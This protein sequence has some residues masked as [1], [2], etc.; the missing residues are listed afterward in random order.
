MGKPREYLRRLRA[1]KGLSS[2]EVADIFGMTR[3]NYSLIETGL[4]QKQMSI[5][6][7]TQ[8][9]ELF[10]ISLD[11][12]ADYEREFREAPEQSEGATA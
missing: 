11:Q 2:Q 10:G 1:E 8:I 5:T 4:A 3:Q 9:S 12:V 7:C 6:I